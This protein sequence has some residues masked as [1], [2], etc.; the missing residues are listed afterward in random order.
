MKWL[1]RRDLLRGAADADAASAT[2]EQSPAEALASA[3][4]PAEPGGL[5]LGQL[6]LDAAES[7]LHSRRRN[8]FAN[9]AR[10][11]SAELRPVAKATSNEALTPATTGTERGKAAERARAKA[12]GRLHPTTESAAK[13][14]TATPAMAIAR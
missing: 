5:L 1:S 6:G 14:A 8:S 2:P 13:S 7:E 3:G 4:L 12:A 9:P 10:G 11:R